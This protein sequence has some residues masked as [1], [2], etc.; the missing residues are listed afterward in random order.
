[1][2]FEQ[3]FHAGDREIILRCPPLETITRFELKSGEL[4]GWEL[5]PDVDC[6]VR[7]R[8]VL[9]LEHPLGSDAQQA[10]VIYTGGYVLPGTAPGPGQ[11]LLPPEIEQAAV[12]QVCF[13]FQNRDR[14]GLS[15]I[16]EYHG[17]YRQY[18]N[19]DLLP[20]VRAVLA[21]HAVW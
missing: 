13:W 9:S 10:R 15:R 19:L 7:R 18:E 3:E 1:V 14:A 12:E 5:K 16:W 4:T 8:C 20:S 11:K 6:I 17:T 21:R 2:D